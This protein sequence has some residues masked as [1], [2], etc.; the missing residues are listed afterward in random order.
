MDTAK[1]LAII[2]LLALIAMI[3]NVLL[4]W[5]NAVQYHDLTQWVDAE[6]AHERWWMRYRHLPIDA[7]IGLER[8]PMVLQPV[9]THGQTHQVYIDANL[10]ERV[11]TNVTNPRGPIYAPRSY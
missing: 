4:R 7:K 10:F 11:L 1:F 8:G 9:N 3:Y 2:A 5:A 6:L